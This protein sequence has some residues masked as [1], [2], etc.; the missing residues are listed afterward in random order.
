MI[1]LFVIKCL[2]LTVSRI[3]RCPFPYSLSNYMDEEGL[4]A[5]CHIHVGFVSAPVS[6]GSWNRL[7]ALTYNASSLEVAGRCHSCR[8]VMNA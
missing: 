4:F 6:Q 8:H 1:Y 7:D 5:L 3:K 2:Y